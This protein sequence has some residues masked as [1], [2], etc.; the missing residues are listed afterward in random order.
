MVN[1]L[2]RICSEFYLLECK[3]WKIFFWSRPICSLQFMVM[4]SPQKTGIELRWHDMKIFGFNSG[5]KLE[6]CLVNLRSCCISLFRR[7]ESDTFV[8]D[9]V[10]LINRFPFQGFGLNDL[11]VR[12]VS[13]ISPADYKTSSLNNEHLCVITKVQKGHFIVRKKFK[14]GLS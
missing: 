13:I 4:S 7:F 2:W 11:L 5:K 10:F 8:Y 9:I 12:E 6:N 1:G 3:I 14:K